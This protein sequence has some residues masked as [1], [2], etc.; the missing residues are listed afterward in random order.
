MDGVWGLAAGPVTGRVAEPA[1]DADP[2]WDVADPPWDW[3]TGAGWDWGTG[4]E[5]EPVPGDPAG[6]GPDDGLWR[7]GGLG[8][9]ALVQ[10]VLS[11]AMPEAQRSRALYLLGL[12]LAGPMRAAAVVVTEPAALP[13]ALRA[14]AVGLLAPPG[15]PDRPPGSAA[16]RKSVV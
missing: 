3:G 4:A 12:A 10:A 5:A 14:C 8:D 15:A 16:D 9:P 11:S 1:R 13:E 2:A 6:A 7:P